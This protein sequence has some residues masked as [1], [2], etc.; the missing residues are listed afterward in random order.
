MTQLDPFTSRR[1]TR[2]IEDCRARQGQLPTLKDLREGGF[3]ESTID[4]A[5]KARLIESF[6]VTLTN[7]NIVKGYK[8]VAPA[9]SK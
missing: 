2:F 3:P 4:L 8:I 7:G 1:I 9:V 5:L 6:Y